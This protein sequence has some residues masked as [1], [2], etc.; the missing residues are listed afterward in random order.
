MIETVLVLT[1]GS[2]LM[3]TVIEIK[4]ETSV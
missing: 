4:N 2:V 3:I 1:K